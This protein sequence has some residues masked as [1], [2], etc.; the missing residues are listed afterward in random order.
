M[1][2]LLQ[3]IGGIYCVYKMEYGNGNIIKPAL[4]Y[5]IFI[6]WIMIIIYIIGKLKN[7][8]LSVDL[9]KETTIFPIQST[10]ENNLLKAPIFQTQIATID[11]IYI[12]NGI[13]LKL[14]TP[15]RIHP[16]KNEVL[17]LNKII[18]SE[19]LAILCA[20]N[21]C[22]YENIQLN[23]YNQKIEYIENIHCKDCEEYTVIYNTLLYMLMTAVC[24]CFDIWKGVLPDK[25]E[26][27]CDNLTNQMN[28]YLNFYKIST[29][30]TE[31]RWW[32]FYDGKPVIFEEVVRKLPVNILFQE[33][34]TNDELHITNAVPKTQLKKKKADDFHVKNDILLKLDTP[35][36]IHL[37]KNQMLFIEKIIINGN[38]TTLCV[39][40]KG[41][42]LNIYDKKMEYIKNIDCK[43][44]EEHMI[45]YNT[46]LYVLVTT[47][48]TCMDIWQDLLPYDIRD[49]CNS[50]TNQMNVHLNSYGIKT[51]LTAQGWYFFYDNKPITFEEVIRKLPDDISFQEYKTDSKLHMSNAVWKYESINIESGYD[52]AA[53]SVVPDGTMF[54]YECA[55]LCPSCNR[56]MNKILL[57]HSIINVS[58]NEKAIDKAFSCKYCNE[59]F[60]PVFN[61]KLSSGFLY[62]LKTDS[63]GYKSI[64]KDMDS[65]GRR[66][67][68][69]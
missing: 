62:H 48:S 69:F 24:T 25:T 35:I 26:D 21:L 5:C 56:F 42:K 30:L 39:D 23:I 8:S 9:S 20:D 14:D 51:E 6:G 32:F 3:W 45:K 13:L 2:F 18:I 52:S 27:I 64:V 12:K 29:R 54:F 44:C 11:N 59:F 46:L 28:V 37:Q 15:I 36:R 60:A 68:V 7:T 4:F 1:L 43:N 67:N 63:Q 31:K 66:N 50:M 61:Q 47:L 58:G 55:Y 40:N 53:Y 65:C 34:K 10:K 49:M 19:H 17:Y 33:Y 16:S 41:I 22:A 57:N 38:L